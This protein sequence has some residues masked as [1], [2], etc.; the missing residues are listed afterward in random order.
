MSKLILKDN[1]F[2]NVRN[3]GK[4]LFM[5]YI[6][7]NTM[8]LVLAARTAD[9]RVDY[10]LWLNPEL[11]S[12]ERIEEMFRIYSAGIMQEFELYD[13]GDFAKIPI[14]WMDMDGTIA[15]TNIGKGTCD[16]GIDISFSNNGDE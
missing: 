1:K 6:N 12:Y 8:K 10:E 11:E 4:D 13:E 5:N 16:L 3:F 9:N 7:T 14:N 15:F 2:T